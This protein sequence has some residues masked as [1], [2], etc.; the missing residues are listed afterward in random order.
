MTCKNTIKLTATN[1]T[2]FKISLRGKSKTL[3]LSC[4]TLSPF[5]H[6]QIPLP[7]DFFCQKDAN[8][9]S[10]E[11]QCGQEEDSPS[12]RDNHCGAQLSSS[13]VQSHSKVDKSPFQ[14][15]HV[16]LMDH[17]K[18]QFNAVRVF[19]AKISLK[20]VITAIISIP[21]K[22]E[23]PKADRPASSLNAGPSTESIMV[24]LFWQF[25]LG[26]EKSPLGLKKNP[27]TTPTTVS[28]LK[29]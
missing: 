16:D 17:C 4:C 15:F 14:L 5:L 21:V 25:G 27:K 2:L 1:S 12:K 22:L 11:H 3:F 24:V 6:T 10:T 8:P 23:I 29:K 26:S 18:T 9:F 20:S 28:F 13:S 7:P 19:L